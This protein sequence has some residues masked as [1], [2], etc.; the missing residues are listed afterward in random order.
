MI[1]KAIINFNWERTF[2]NSSV[3][4]D[5][6]FFG[7]TLKNIFCNYIPNRKIKF[8]YSKPKWMTP[9]ILVAL[10]KGQNS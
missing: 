5:V 10:K 3:N 8:D 1:Q 7:E 9:K 6:R 4:E 2:S